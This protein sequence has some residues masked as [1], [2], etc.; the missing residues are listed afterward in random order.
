MSS[1]QLMVGR[2]VSLDRVARPDDIGA[3]R[4]QVDHLTVIDRHG[5]AVVDDV[6]LSVGR[7][8]VL[9]IAGVQGNGQTELAETLLG[10]ERPTQGRITLD[11]TDLTRADPQECVRSGVG[12][13]P[14][15]RANDGFVPSFSVA[16]NLVLDLLDDPRFARRGIL[17]P[18]AVRE[19]AS[20]RVA[21]FD[22]RTQSV[23][24]PG[25]QPLRRQSAEG[26]AGPRDVPAT[27]ASWWPASRLGDSTLGRSS[28][29]T[30]A[31]GRHATP[32]PPC[33]WCRPSSTR[34]T[35]SRIASR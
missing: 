33:C 4:L 20:Q 13:I 3:D 14:E 23:G 10:L 25:R 9:G 29:C 24:T 22:I 31:S 8:E 2:S 5:V 30:V 11:G 6:T 28:S 26:G 17:S 21:E 35:S 16:E 32:G 7:G 1:P 19:N 27:R 18:D 15:D 12:Y 34:S